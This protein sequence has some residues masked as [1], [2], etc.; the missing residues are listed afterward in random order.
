MKKLQMA[1]AAWEP[2]SGLNAD[3]V[4]VLRSLWPAIVGDEVAA[5]SRPAEVVRDALVIVTRSS[6]WSQQLQFLSER[7][8][9][10]VHERADVPVE[11]L[12]FR[13]GR[14]MDQAAPAGQKRAV[15]RRRARTVRDPAPNLEAALARFKADVTAA[16]RAKAGA[17]WKECARCGVRIVPSSGPRCTPCENARMQERDARVARLLF[18]APWLGYAGIA[19]LVEQLTPHEYQ[20]I[21]LQLLRRWKDALERVRRSGGAVLTTRD[22][23]IASSYVLLESELDPERIAPA[24]VRNLL[25][26]ELH[27]IFYGTG[28]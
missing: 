11:R 3:P 4:V 6:A 15:P 23:M 28:T 7:I 8:L 27:D 26:N 20:L 16:Q 9:A 22:R 21:R 14:V 18:E 1:V 10:A 19:P 5:N 24:V 25:G 2:Q 17:G 13:V 12:R